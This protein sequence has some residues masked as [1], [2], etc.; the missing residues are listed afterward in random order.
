MN[1][2]LCINPGCTNSCMKKKKNTHY[3]KHCSVKCRNQHISIKGA[4]KRKQTC[5]SRY[6]TTTNLSHQE[7]K[8]KIKKTIKEKYGVEHIM[9]RPESKEK[10]QKTKSE[11][12]GDST[13]NNRTKFIETKNTWSNEKRQEIHDKKVSTTRE[14]Y[15]VDYTT[16]SSKMKEQSRATN[17]DRYGYENA[18]SSPIVIE[19]IRNTMVARYGKHYNQRH[20]SDESLNKLNDVDFLEEN[21]NKPLKEVANQLGISYY[22]LDDAFTRANITRTF[23]NCNRSLA[24]REIGDYIE[25]V[26]GIRTETNNRSL[27]N[28]KEVDIY[29]P[30]HKI[31][32]EYHGLYWHSEGTGT[33]KTYH[34]DKL[35]NA[36]EAGIHLIQITDY[37]WINHQEL[38]KSRIAT[39]LGKGKVVYAR[40]C[41]V[42]LVTADECK[43]FLTRTHI[44]GMVVSTIRL[45]L[46]YNEKLIAVMTFGKSRFNNDAEWELLRYSSELHTTVV[47]GA[48]KLFTYF[49]KNYYPTSVISFCDLRWNTGKMYEHLGFQHIRTSKP[50]YWYCRNYVTFESRVVYQ[51]HKLEKL[52]TTFDPSLSEWENMRLNGYDRFWDCGNKVFLWKNEKTG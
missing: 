2:P 14:R 1:I 28:G 22:T 30:D 50:N 27:L 24:E 23:V 7:T 51:K 46:Y 20:I 29:I 3:L 36:N 26:L 18:A 16:Q 40:K 25:N 45:G 32:I 41:K 49:I 17:L 15:G 13:Y 31:G 42:K 8:D 47:G 38:V 10:L 12:Y 52:L 34:L 33:H 5:L 39:K 9:H 44:Q 6:G 4:E 11:K 19:K 48:S 35:N 43:T 21:K 37:E